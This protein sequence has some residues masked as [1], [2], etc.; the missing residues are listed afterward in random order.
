[1]N[2]ILSP[3]MIYFAR[4]AFSYFITILVILS[5]VVSLSELVEYNKQISNLIDE[6]FYLCLKMTLYKIPINIQNLL[7]YSFYFGSMMSL[8]R[9]SK[10]SELIIARSSGLNIWYCC[11]PHL[12]LAFVIGIFSITVFS[13]ITA[14]TQTKLSQLEGEYLNKYNNNLQLSGGG[15]WLY[16]KEGDKTSIIHADKIEPQNMSLNNVIIFRYTKD[17]KFFERIDGETTKLEKGYW[18]IDRGIKTN[19][20]LETSEFIELQLPTK[21]TSSQ[22]KESFAK[23]ETISFWETLKFIEII[24][25]A[26]FNSRKHIIHYNKMLS[27]PIYLIGM[28]LLGAIFSVKPIGRHGIGKRL[29]IAIILAFVI[30]FLNDV[31]AALGQGSQASAILAAWIPAFVPIFLSTSILLYLE[32]G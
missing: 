24:E 1:M 19:K 25:K 18:K 26:G 6:S 10:N 7:P 12:L 15:F 27:T 4:H 30:F 28:V 5:F 20:D 9:L 2:F 32:D 16:Q 3:L 11:L 14:V 8:I 22:I 17:N 21:L 13:S 29:F 23:P 31:I